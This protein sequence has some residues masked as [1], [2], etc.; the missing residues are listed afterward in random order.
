MG[1]VELTVANGHKITLDNVLFIPN[2]AVRLL[3]ALTLNCS[4]SFISHFD[5]QQCWVTKKDNM[6]ILWGNIIENKRLYQLIAFKP[7]VFHAKHTT[8]SALYTTHTA[9]IETW[10]QHLGHCNI[11]TIVDMAKHKAADG[12][13]INLS[14]IPP[15]CT[16]CIL[17]KQTRSSIPKTC[18]GPKATRRLE[19]IYVDLMGPMSVTSRLGKAYLMNIMDD[20]TSYIWSIPLRSKDEAA[21]MLQTWQHIVENQCDVVLLWLKPVFLRFL[22]YLLE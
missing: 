4:G 20:F 12:M 11:H 14:T 5:S 10:H 13:M 2:S 15:K 9:D 16:H 8:S 17:G 18:E 22:R 19:H 21:I 1:T 6:V 3:S 7:R